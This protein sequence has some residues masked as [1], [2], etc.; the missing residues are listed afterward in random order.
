M[1]NRRSNG[2]SFYARWRWR[3]ACSVVGFIITRQQQLSRRLSALRTCIGLLSLHSTTEM[4]AFK[5]LDAQNQLT[6]GWILAYVGIDIAVITARV[7]FIVYSHDL[8]CLLRAECAHSTGQICLKFN[9]A[10]TVFFS[11]KFKFHELRRE[12]IF[13]HLFKTILEGICVYRSF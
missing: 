9:N 8:S 7:S 1:R 13:N 6:S 10:A 2:L 11:E 3:S 4:R 5:G 12:N